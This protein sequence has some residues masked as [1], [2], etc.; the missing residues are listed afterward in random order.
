MVSNIIQSKYYFKNKDQFLYFNIIYEGN[1]FAKTIDNLDSLKIFTIHAFCQQLLSRF[2]IEARISHNFEVIDESKSLALIRESIENLLNSSET[3]QDIHRSLRLLIFEKNEEDFYS[4]INYLISKRKNFELMEKFDYKNELKKILAIGETDENGIIDQFNSHSRSDLLTLCETL[5]NHVD[6]GGQK[7]NDEER[8]RIVSEF[9]AD[10]SENNRKTYL[11]I[12]LTRKFEKRNLGNKFL[13][14]LNDLTGPLGSNIYVEEQERCYSFVQNI[15]NVR[16]YNLTMAAIDVTLGIVRNYRKLKHGRGLLDFDDL[17][18]TTLELLNNS[19]QSMW[20]NY[21][22]DCEIEHILIDEAQD[23]STLQWKI[24]ES[25]SGDFFTGVGSSKNP[26][27]LFVV[28]DEKQSIFKF[29]DANPGMFSEK[30]H[31][32]RNLI[33][34]CG[35]KLFKLNLRQ[36]FRSVA[37]I[38]N[39]VDEVFRDQRNAKKISTLDGTI[40]HSS[41][42]MG[43]GLVELWPLVSIEAREK[44]AWEINFDNNAEA[45]KQ[46]LLAKYIG[47]K[48]A[49]LVQS[50]RVIID[51]QGNYRKIGYGDIMVLVRSRNH[52]FLSYLLKSFNEHSIP[53]AGLDRLNLFDHIVVQDFISL[54]TFT[55]FQN[56]DLS[57]AN[58]I[59]SPFLAM[60][61]DDLYRICRYG[62]EH[63]I[64]LF[65]ALR[66]NFLEKY[67][68][69]RQIIDESHRLGVYELC[70]Y[71][72]EDCGFREKILRRFSS[73]TNDILNK[74]LLFVQNYEDDNNSSL[75]SF[76]NFVA[77]SKSDIKKNLESND[78]NQVRIMTIHASKGLQAPV[79]FIGDSNSTVDLAREKI[80]WID[81]GRGYEQPLY[82]SDSSSNILDRIKKN[83]EEE[84]YSEYL[85][86]F[87]VAI[88]RAENELYLCGVA[89]RSST[90]NDDEA[91]HSTWYDISRKALEKLG[92]REED[93]EFSHRDEVGNF[94]RKFTY[95]EASRNK[96]QSDTVAV[97]ND[98][99]ELERISRALKNIRKYVPQELPRKIIFPSTFF[100]Y[101]DRDVSSDGYGDPLLKG[102]M[103]HRLLEILPKVDRSHWDEISSSISGRMAKNLP[104]AI[105]DEAKKIAVGILD[106]KD[107]QKFFEENSK[108]EVPIIGEIDGF[109]VSGKIDRLGEFDGKI[110]VLD[111][112]NTKNNYKNPEDLP[113]EYKKQLELYKKLMEKLKPEKIV[114]CYILL[115]SFGNLLRIF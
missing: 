23:T 57:L 22:L 4:F 5:A 61:E 77:N 104:L 14:R 74:F 83:S 45:K 15:E 24:V 63:G 60:A 66:D 101:H 113:I 42:R 34:G 10:G 88:T 31:F 99:F 106:S 54:F 79:V 53:N 64:C 58:I 68:I 102:K 67:E 20:I 89:G 112:K 100:N 59:K 93:F 13:K 35:K 55:L 28:G 81:S 49:T 98:E 109:T 17:I 2:P 115:T 44:K 71:L 16:N 97:E 30:Y 108:A 32:Y 36:S 51:R 11:N 47:E 50:D 21:K 72:L 27:S 1:L 107:F 26:R 7:V 94:D 92:A 8:L 110:I 114:E 78:A 105:I 29:Q 37:T 19:E 48:I 65:E 73:D 111:Y 80:F 103:V 41:S 9:I 56:D 39:F 52:I 82:K 62:M 38:L 6:G 91:V 70:F 25:L 18:I 69:L 75:L 12:F 85:R 84:L 90:D 40:E 33:E 95:G 86:L 76:V 43:T 96:E 87:Y 3:S 46:E